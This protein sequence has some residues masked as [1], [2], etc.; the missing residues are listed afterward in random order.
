MENLTALFWER[1]L[2]TQSWNLHEYSIR[3]KH[4]GVSPITGSLPRM[5]SP[6]FSG[7]S[8]WLKWIQRTHLESKKV[9]GDEDIWLRS[10][11]AKVNLESFHLPT[12]TKRVVGNLLVLLIWG[13]I[14]L[15]FFFSWFHSVVQPGL[16]LM[17]LLTSPLPKWWDYKCELSYLASWNIQYS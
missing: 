1:K 15:L 4:Y 10:E 17:V 9:A 13:F 16:E 2:Q 7:W 12:N 3:L 5:L 6:L 14:L 8:F 11:V